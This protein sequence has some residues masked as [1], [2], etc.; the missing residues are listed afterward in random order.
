M[1]H[2]CHH[3]AN[4]IV[5]FEISEQLA[6][7]FQGVGEQEPVNLTI[8]FERRGLCM[9]YCLESHY[10]T[11]NKV[12]GVLEDSLQA[13]EHVRREGSI[14]LLL[15]LH[16]DLRFPVLRLGLVDSRDGGCR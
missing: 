3:G 13:V 8:W 15:Q 10:E 2:L 5:G 9:S 4:Q 1:C 12:V 7:D 6:L 14:V 16:I 11:I